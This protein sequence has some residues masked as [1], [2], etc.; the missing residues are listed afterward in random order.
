MIA[1]P[2]RNT[3][4]LSAT[5][6]PLPSSEDFLH[7]IKSA[8]Y[9][10]VLTVQQPAIRSIVFSVFD[11]SG[12]SSKFTVIVRVKVPQD[13]TCVF[14]P[15]NADVVFLLDSSTTSSY[16]KFWNYIGAF[17]AEVVNSLPISAVSTRYC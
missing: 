10:H 9:D 14:P 3:F 5:Q 7:V 12:A 4:L 13:L 1:S 2:A 11:S 17:T 8:T 6:S 15:R 16:P